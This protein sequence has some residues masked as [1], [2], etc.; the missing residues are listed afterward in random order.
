MYA[1]SHP[2]VLNS[3]CNNEWMNQKNFLFDH[4]T[5][6]KVK[7]KYWLEILY[8][9]CLQ[10]ILH[11]LTTNMSLNYVYLKKRHLLVSHYIQTAYATTAVT[12]IIFCKLKM[13]LYKAYQKDFGS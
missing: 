11:K 5:L 4:V 7:C 9:I 13:S 10:M 8:F 6:I 3:F 1:K 12:S 2:I